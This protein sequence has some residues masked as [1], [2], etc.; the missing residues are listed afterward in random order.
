DG[1]EIHLRHRFISDCTRT[2]YEN[3][4]GK[5]IHNDIFM[6]K[7]QYQNGGFGSQVFAAEVKGARDQGFDWIET[8]AARSS[9]TFNGYYTW[10]TLGYDQ[11]LS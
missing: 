2:I 4:E 11:R 8:H 5:Y 3:R 6:L 10:A 9:G 1:E 7:K